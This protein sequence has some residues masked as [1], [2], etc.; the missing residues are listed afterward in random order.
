MAFRALSRILVDSSF[1]ELLHAEGVCG[2][3]WLLTAGFE[4]A[5]AIPVA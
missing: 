4:D 1:L 5:N 2:L 3:S